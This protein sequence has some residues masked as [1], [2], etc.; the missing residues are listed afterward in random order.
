VKDYITSSK[1]ASKKPQ[2]NFRWLAI[3]SGIMLV[4]IAGIITWQHHRHKIVAADIVTGNR[5][6]HNPP[7]RIQL[8]SA[9]S[10]TQHSPTKAI[11]KPAIK[12]QFD[13]YHLLGEI[14]VTTGSTNSPN[15]EKASPQY[16]YSVQ[17]AS[18]KDYTAALALQRSLQAK[19]ID[20]HIV[21][22]TGTNNTTWYKIISGPF[23][24]VVLAQNLQDKLRLQNINALLIRQKAPADTDLN[25]ED[26]TSQSSS[27]LKQTNL[28]D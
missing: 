27:T 4:L 10:A 19:Q 20:S 13:F 5:L 18:S 14:Q 8:H 7:P 15:D 6:P 3:S 16:I 12:P 1:P 21:T 17:A 11:T 22:K 23:S 25:P 28:T 2:K 26:K 9:N 24:D